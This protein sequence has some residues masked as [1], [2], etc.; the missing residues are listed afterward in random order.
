MMGDL[1]H[2]LGTSSNAGKTT[3]TLSVIKTLRSKGY[4]VAPFKA[5][6]MSLNSIS[7]RD[8]SEISRAQWLQAFG[9]GIEPEA[10]MN[11]VLIKPEGMGKSQVILMGKSIG[12][13]TVGQYGTLISGDIKK[14]VENII[15]EKKG[16]YDFIVAEG[17]GGCSEINLYDRDISNTWLTKISKGKGFIVGN[18]EYGGVFGSIFGSYKLSQYPETIKGFIINKMLGDTKILD[19]G[20]KKIENLTGLKH[21]GTVPK[22]KKE[23]LPG[24]DSIDY[25]FKRDDGKVGIIKYPYWENYSDLDS[26]Y[27]HN[28]ARDIHKDIPEGLKAI[29]LPGSKNVFMDIKYLRDTGMD[30]RIKEI[31][32]SDVKIIGIC[33]GF[34]ILGKNIYDERT[35]DREYGLGIIP[36][37]FHYS[38]EKTVRQINYSGEIDGISFEGNGYEIHY[39]Q[40]S[41]EIKKPFAMTD[42]G[43][44]GYFDGNILGTNI[45]GVLENAKILSWLAETNIT[46]NYENILNEIV[47]KFSEN[48]SRHIDIETMIQI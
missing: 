41:G 1:L 24:E 31:A 6:N 19:D 20:I 22:V 29:I 43:R 21:I 48:I 16:E 40:V 2:I 36:Y 9:A 39:G 47:T 18:I 42:F 8:G 28:L 14:I 5:M 10:W 33:G 34:Q 3:I 37:D 4:R 17:A 23:F 11:P 35:G 30:K 45:H 44:E 12:I 32:K 13:R 26:V 46:K 25:D 15:N 27:Y 7:T 38:K